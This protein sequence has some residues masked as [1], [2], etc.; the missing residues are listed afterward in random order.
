MAEDIT[1]NI[2]DK[3]TVDR[4]RRNGDIELPYKT[5]D[6][7]KDMR[8]NTKQMASKLLQG[9]L[10]GDSIPKIAESLTAVIGN[11]KASAVRNARTMITG[12]ENV[13]R[14]DS[15]KDLASQGVVQKKIWIATP[16]DRTRESHIDVDGEEVDINQVFS[17]GLEYPGDPNGDPSE[18]YNCRCSMRTHIIGFRRSDGSISYVG[19]DRDDTMHNEQME[20]K[21]EKQTATKNVSHVVN[22]KDI[23]QTWVRR[24]D[25]FDFEIED[26][27][28]AQGFDGLPQVVSADE[29]DRYV[30]ESNF[31]A[32]RTYSAP[33]QETLD[34]YREQLYNG[35]WY[36]DCS[37]GGAQHGQ[38]MYCAGNYEGKLTEAIKQ[39][40]RDYQNQNLTYS[41]EKSVHT[42][43]T[44][45]LDKNA[46]I[47]NQKDLVI[48]WAREYNPSK[49]DWWAQVGGPDNIQDAAIDV[50]KN[51]RAQEL[52]KEGL[53]NND[54]KARMMLNDEIK[55]LN[56]IE[57]RNYWLQKAGEAGILTDN[58]SYAALKGYD[59]IRTNHG[60]SGADTIILNRTKVIFKGE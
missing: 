3:D 22:G 20:V 48:E 28:N 52:V 27:I 45:T 6:I 58:G 15:Y 43:E 40:M 30:E 19:H 54:F 13:G 26:V 36:V 34:A 2:V 53:A 32:Q 44:I 42:I 49:A 29:F 46:R 39:E 9:I 10:N 5:V 18:V 4:L 57:E 35:K 11:N 24:S 23:S 47:I 55:G 8:W 25:Q 50:V 12:A 17:N 14:L 41:G 7:D 31:I 51:I 33:N 1:F 16:D 56:S 60:T 59:A 37:T 38:G 21:K